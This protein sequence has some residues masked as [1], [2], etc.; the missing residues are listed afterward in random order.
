[1]KKIFVSY[2]RSDS[3][4]VVGRILDRIEAVFG[5]DHIF[6][7]LDSIDYGQDFGVAIH[8][9]LAQS[10]VLLAVIGDDWANVRDEDG[11]RRLDNPNDWVRKE[12][13]KSLEQ[14]IHVIPVLVENAQFPTENELPGNLKELVNRNAAKVRDD[15]DFDVDM[16]RLC[17][18]I[19]KTVPDT[20]KPATEKQKN[21]WI[22][23]VLATS[24]CLLFIVSAIQTG[25][26]G[27]FGRENLSAPVNAEQ[28]FV[29]CLDSYHEGFV[30]DQDTRSE[31]ST[32]ADDIT[33]AINDL[34]ITVVSD[35]TSPTWDGGQIKKLNPA[36]IIV[37]ASAFLD[38]DVIFGNGSTNEEKNLAYAAGHKMILNLFGSY[39]NTDTQFIVY[40]RGFGTPEAKEQT[41]VSFLQ[42]FP[43]IKGKVTAL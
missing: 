19:R 11:K 5:E 28:T 21:R 10:E 27:S 29:I 30:Y 18:A 37:H 6:R 3:S 16:Q 15:P 23:P 7:D 1:M 42:P 2:R 12:I 41:L 14:G 33:R 24:L 20:G 4:T 39:R 35:T 40:S 43:E 17:D 38:G 26:F 36:L 13:S 8:G 34:P 22:W 32:N 31:K 9:A 25:F